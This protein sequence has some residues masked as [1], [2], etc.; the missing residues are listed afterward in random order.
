MRRLLPSGAS[1]MSRWT[2]AGSWDVQMHCTRK[3]CAGLA[4]AVL[5]WGVLPPSSRC[6][7]PSPCPQWTVSPPP[8]FVSRLHITPHWRVEGKLCMGRELGKLP[9]SPNEFSF[10]QLSLSFNSH[11]PGDQRVYYQQM[12]D[13]LNKTGRHMLYNTCA[14]GLATAAHAVCTR[15]L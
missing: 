10:L 4:A 2:T 5:N 8:L 7:L 12:R 6:A 11:P 9:Y 1:I 3:P 13:A 15:R 14:C